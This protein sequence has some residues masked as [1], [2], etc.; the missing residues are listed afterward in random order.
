MYKWCPRLLTQITVWC[1]LYFLISAEG[2]LDH[3][4]L[5]ECE[6][7]GGGSFGN[8]YKVTI[9]GKDYAAKEFNFK[10]T[11]TQLEQKKSE[12][13][14][15]PTLNNENIVRYVGVHNC[16]PGQRPILVMELMCCTLQA[17]LTPDESS[18]ISIDINIMDPKVKKRVALDVIKGL[19]YLHSEDDKA[20]VIHRD[21]TAKNVLLDFRGIAK[22]ADFGYARLL[23]HDT[24]ASMTRGPGTLNYMAPEIQKKDY[25]EKVD[26]FSYGHLLL[27][28]FIGEDP[29]DLPPAICSSSDGK[30]VKGITELCR[31]EKYMKILEERCKESDFEMVINIVKNCLSNSASCRPS[32]III[33]NDLEQ[34]PFQS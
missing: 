23:K 21:L 4:A 11:A 22:I 7:F 18:D 24:L 28:L 30:T 12:F 31:R 13:N 19:K 3:A 17:L 1:N 15:L 14:I 25:D 29:S 26:I 5:S 9:D 27:F 16:V 20:I 34:P 8:V 2:C 10:Y 6:H 32:A 33:V